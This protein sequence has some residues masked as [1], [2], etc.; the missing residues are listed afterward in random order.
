RRGSP[1]PAPRPRWAPP[2]RFVTECLARTGKDRSGLAADFGSGYGRN[3]LAAA[4]Q[5][6]NTT[7]FDLDRRALMSLMTHSAMHR[8]EID[9]QITAVCAD[10]SQPSLIRP[11]SFALVMLIE[12]SNEINVRALV[13]AV[14]PGGYLILETFQDRGE[15][16]R[17]LPSPGALRTLLGVEFDLLSYKEIPC[18]H[19]EGARCT[20]K[21]FAR[22]VRNAD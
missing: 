13:S 17:G 7:A 20:A 5:G 6:W 15:N 3:T 4:A 8:D 19:A 11:A 12:Y 16:W 2:S 22:R 14:R 21:V 10:L 1:R 18:R 9:G